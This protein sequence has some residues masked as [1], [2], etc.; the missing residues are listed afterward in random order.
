MKE[1]RQLIM[2]AVLEGK[3]P[4]ES[5]TM[6]ELEEVEDTLFELICAKH[7]QFS[8]WETLQ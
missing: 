1:D 6:E 8:T 7:T 3:L 4:P 2:L 5:V